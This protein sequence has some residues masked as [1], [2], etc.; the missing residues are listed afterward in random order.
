MSKIAEAR[1][2]DTPAPYGGT[3]GFKEPTTSKESAIKYRGRAK[4]LLPKVFDAIVAAGAAG[5]TADEAASILGETVLAIRP[6][7]TELKEI[8]EIER[9]GERR[10]NV[11]GMSAAVWIKKRTA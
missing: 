3:P 11:S 8:G 1:Y 2:G 9:S 6:R 10:K 5:L 4:V 7:V